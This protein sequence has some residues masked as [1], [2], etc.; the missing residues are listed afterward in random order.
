MLADLNNLLAAH[1]RGE[2]TEDRFRDF[3]DKHGDLFPENPQN[4]DELIDALARRQAAAERLLSSL[5]RE[6]REQLAQLMADA[7][8]DPDLA[9]QMAQL[10]DNLRAL[11]PGLDRSSPVRG[12]QPGGE[13]M[14]WG[15]AV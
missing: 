6:Q 2:D 11:R 15:Q 9:S 8:G 13:P 4:V 12:G 5:S 10:S 1:A 14:P 7:L 3:M